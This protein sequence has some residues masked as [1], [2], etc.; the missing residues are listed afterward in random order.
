MVSER[1]PA[2]VVTPVRTVGS[3]WPFA[4]TIFNYTRRAMPYQAPMSLTNDEYYAITAFILNRN[5]IIASDT[6]IDAS[7]LPAI[8]M[9]NNGGFIN[10]YPQVPAEYDYRD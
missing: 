10:A 2:A 5:D 3:Y 4:S 9:P 8:E 7:S 1:K 6:V